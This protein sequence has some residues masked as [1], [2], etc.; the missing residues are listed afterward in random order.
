MKNPNMR[1]LPIK[2]LEKKQKKAQY[3]WLLIAVLA[4]LLIGYLVWKNALSDTALLSSSAPI[5]EPVEAIMPAST[6][7]D[8]ESDNTNVALEEN[9][10][11]SVPSTD[12]LTKPDAILN[13]PMPTTDSLAKEESY[14]LD[15]ESA[16]GAEQEKSL[17]EQM[18][19][20]KQ[21]SEMK[22]EQIALLEQ[23]IAKLEAKNPVETDVE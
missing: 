19:M 20:N 8:S 11:L 18:T 9:A 15:D 12:Q 3:K 14:R 10:D 17:K 23:Q 21:L 1:P 7:L 13:A 4:A 16:R 5:T 22:A 2:L 6:P